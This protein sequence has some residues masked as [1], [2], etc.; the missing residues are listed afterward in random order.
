[1]DSVSGHRRGGDL[2]LYCVHAH[3][4]HHQRKQLTP[5]ICACPR[6]TAAACVVM[7][8]FVLERSVKHMDDD[9]APLTL[10]VASQP[11]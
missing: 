8:N 9:C 6:V 5:T 10:Y 4:A 1:M 2:R 11:G 7:R 3:W